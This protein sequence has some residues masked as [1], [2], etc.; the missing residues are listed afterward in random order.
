M[1]R[2]DR[3]AAREQAREAAEEARKS[4]RKRMLIK[5]GIAIALFVVAGFVAVVT[6]FEIPVGMALLGAL[7]FTVVCIGLGIRARQ[8]F[9][10]MED[11][12]ECVDGE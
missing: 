1:G 11:D 5:G 6:V 9:G 12:D 8:L 3:Q 4:G 2:K 10:V 7:V